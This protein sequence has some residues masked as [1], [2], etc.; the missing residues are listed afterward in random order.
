MRHQYMTMSDLY[1]IELCAPTL[2][3]ANAAAAL[4]NRAQS[5]ILLPSARYTQKAPQKV[6]PAPVVSNECT[7]AA[8]TIGLQSGEY[9]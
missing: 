5:Y 8:F 7:F 3:V 4:A 6:L 9:T 2:V 1:G